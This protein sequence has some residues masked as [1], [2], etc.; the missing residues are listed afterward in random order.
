VCRTAQDSTVTAGQCS[1]AQ[2]GR[3]MD[4]GRL[5]FGVTWELE[6]SGG[7]AR[8][9]RVVVGVRLV[10]CCIAH[11]SKRHAGEGVEA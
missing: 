8:C 5:V 6:L 7:W 3:E 2:D 4:I 10:E 9:S 11:H 1:A